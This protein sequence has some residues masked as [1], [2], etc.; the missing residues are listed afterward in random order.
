MSTDRIIPATSPQ[1]NWCVG[2]LQSF[3]PLFFTCTNKLIIY[4]ER[5]GSPVRKADLNLEDDYVIGCNSAIAMPLNLVIAKRKGSLAMVD[6]RT[7][8]I[9]DEVNKNASLPPGKRIA[10][11][12]VHREIPFGF[13]T[14]IDNSSFTTM[15]DSGSL[16][17]NFKETSLPIHS[18][19][20]HATEAACVT[21]SG[22]CAKFLEVRLD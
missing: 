14:L 7:M 10:M 15:F 13:G 18:F 1:E 6:F 22:S 17:I 20:L 5:V 9:V 3:S 16:S 11:F 21:R 8:S 19:A 4:D 2:W 12:K